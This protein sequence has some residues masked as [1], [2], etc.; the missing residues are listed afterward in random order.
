MTDGR[1]LVDLEAVASLAARLTELAATL[2][3]RER[4]IL[5]A[6]SGWFA[7]PIDRAGRRDPATLLSDDEQRLL[8]QL[9]AEFGGDR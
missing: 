8:D 2:S 9:V 4:A 6:M 5:L 7:D 1:E 3:P